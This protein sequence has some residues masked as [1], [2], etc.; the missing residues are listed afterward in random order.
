MLQDAISQFIIRKM[1]ITELLKGGME[2]NVMVR[3]L[4]L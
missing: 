2:Y 4:P 3:F 1:F